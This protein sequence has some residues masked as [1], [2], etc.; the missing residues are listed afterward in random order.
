MLEIATELPPS[1]E[2]P[3][4]S[5]QPPHEEVENHNHKQNT[6]PEEIIALTT[7][8]QEPN[9]MELP[10]IAILDILDI[11]QVLRMGP[12]HYHC[13]PF[14]DP[15]HSRKWPPEM[16][17]IARRSRSAS[18]LTFLCASCGSTRLQ[19]KSWGNIQYTQYTITIYYCTTKPNLY[20]IAILN[21]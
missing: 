8:K 21:C 3:D 1:Y 10:I 7:I 9:A 15:F 18:A 17:L 4:F 11:Y 19:A 14:G 12:G 13:Q 5:G 6:C 16:S 2:Y 20:L